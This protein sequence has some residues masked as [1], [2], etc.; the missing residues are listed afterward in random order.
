M[1]AKDPQPRKPRTRRP[2]STDPDVV[3]LQK[4]LSSTGVKQPRIPQRIDELLSRLMAR[5]GYAEVSSQVEWSQTWPKVAGT[6]AAMTRPGRITRGVLEVWVKNSTVLQ[7]AVFRKA[8]WIR[9]IQQE[10]PHCRVQDL[11]FRVGGVG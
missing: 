3:D 9:Q 11:R 10:M 2:A 6:L 8:A 7:E 1:N 5:R 4:I